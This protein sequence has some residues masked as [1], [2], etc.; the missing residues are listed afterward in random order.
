MCRQFFFFLTR[1][2]FGFTI[3]CAALCAHFFFLLMIKIPKRRMCSLDRK[4]E[5]FEDTLKVR[6][7][8]NNRFCVR[9]R[10]QYN[11]CTHFREQCFVF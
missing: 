7:F 10:T 3:M 5:M 2:T 6:F 9:D 4:F 11:M 1:N 8:F